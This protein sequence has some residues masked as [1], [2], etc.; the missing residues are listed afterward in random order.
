MF[1]RWNKSDE[2]A[3]LLSPSNFL[4]ERRF[5][6]W[7]VRWP[8]FTWSVWVKSTWIVPDTQTWVSFRWNDRSAT[9]LQADDAGFT[10]KSDNLRCL[11][12]LVEEYASDLYRYCCHIYWVFLLLVVTVLEDVNTSYLYPSYLHHRVSLVELTGLAVKRV[13]VVMLLHPLVLP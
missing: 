13:Q 5:L 4:L 11:V 10:D 6:W 9:Y 8:W 2:P 1:A 12:F 3:G 7:F